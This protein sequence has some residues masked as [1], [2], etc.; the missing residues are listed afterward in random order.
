[1]N[2][3]WY[4]RTWNRGFQPLLWH[5]HCHSGEVNH[6]LKCIILGIYITTWETNGIEIELSKLLKLLYWNI[7]ATLLI[8]SVA[9]CSTGLPTTVTS[10]RG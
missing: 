2:N 1:M 8:Y 4:P 3:L 5:D 6:H 9:G 7:W 10:S